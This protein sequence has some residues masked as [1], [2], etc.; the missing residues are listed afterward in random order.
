MCH[1]CLEEVLKV[2][3]LALVKGAVVVFAK[4][5]GLLVPQAAKHLPGVLDFK[6]LG[7][8]SCQQT[9]L[10]TAQAHGLP[11][12]VYQPCFNQAYWAKPNCA[13]SGDIKIKIPTKTTR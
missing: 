13:R 11:V 5:I 7:N 12:I 3:G 1:Y 2:Q 9:T 6:L 10:G 8:G 4:S